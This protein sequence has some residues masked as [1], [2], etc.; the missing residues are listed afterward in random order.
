MQAVA[1]DALG[2]W[3]GPESLVRL[4]SFLDE[5]F[6]REA[7]WSIRGVAVRN[8]IP[9]LTASDAGWVLDM[10]WDRPSGLEKHEL[11]R[12][13]PV[14]VGNRGSRYRRRVAHLAGCQQAV[15]IVG[16]LENA[17]WPQAREPLHMLVETI[18]RR[19]PI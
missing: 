15:F 18:E 10:Y 3:G 14:L 6:R 13:P 8:L 17:A 9:L 1:L 5:A 19:L 4:R 2:R 11:L 12:P 7:G 16:R